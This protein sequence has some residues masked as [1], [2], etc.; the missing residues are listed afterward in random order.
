[1]GCG[2]RLHRIEL[3]DRGEAKINNIP[4]DDIPVCIEWCAPGGDESIED[5]DSYSHELAKA[6]E[7]DVRLDDGVMPE[8]D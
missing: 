5:R 4:I 7:E 6:E 8:F 3:Y 1:V 2:Q